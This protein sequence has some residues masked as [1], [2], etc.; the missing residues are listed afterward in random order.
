M[1]WRWNAA[2]E[3]EGYRTEKEHGT[4]T[5]DGPGQPVVAD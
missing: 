5:M 4:G 2:V 1:M 3:S